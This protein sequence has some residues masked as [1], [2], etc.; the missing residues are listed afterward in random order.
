MR[1]AFDTNV[2]LDILT[3]D[4]RYFDRVYDTYFKNLPLVL[5]GD[6]PDN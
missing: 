3:N 5:Y 4:A 1:T 6:P 2:L